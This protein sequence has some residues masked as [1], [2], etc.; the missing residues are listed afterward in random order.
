M[1]VMAEEPRTLLCIPFGIESS[2]QL[3]SSAILTPDGARALLW[4]DLRE[5]DL[6]SVGWSSAFVELQSLPNICANR[7]QKSLIPQMVL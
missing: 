5:L 4:D 6:L 2:S 3:L 7:E 1:A